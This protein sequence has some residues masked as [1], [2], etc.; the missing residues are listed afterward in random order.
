MPITASQEILKSIKNK[1][2]KPIYFLSGEETYFIDIIADFIEENVLDAAEK[3]FNQT[4]VYGPDTNFGELQETLKR[5]PMMSE[6]QVV[7][8][9]EAQAMRNLKENLNEYLQNP[10]S[11]SILVICFKH[12]KTSDK[13]FINLIKTKGV[14]FESDRLREDKI[15]AWIHGYLKRK[16][17]RIGERTAYML[18][19]YLG[20]EL[21]KMANEL[22]KLAIVLPPDSEITEDDIEANIG[23]SKDFNS[24]ELINALA[25]KNALKANRII[26]YFAAN[27]KNHPLP[28]TLSILFNFFSKV[29]A[30]QYLEDKSSR[31]AA[32]KL[33]VPPFFMKD[34]IQGARNYSPGKSVKIID[35]IRDIDLKS[36]GV[37]NTSADDGELM[38][39]LVF[40]ILH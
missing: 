37:D 32:S 23:I 1:E 10:I 27:K 30:Y 26:N 21:S 5:F 19:E 40:N 4:V 13:K 24:F 3:E 29:L 11:S 9:R 12:K 8:V 33:G 15:P 6:Y 17:L 34:Y 31:N 25:N 14:Y 18:V 22:D 36:K 35:L 38:K 20:T 28:V 39:E 16:K 2:Y 7:I